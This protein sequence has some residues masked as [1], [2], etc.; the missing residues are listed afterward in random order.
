MKRLVTFLILISSCQLFSEESSESFD[1][2]H[3][4]FIENKNSFD[5][6]LL[7]IQ[8]RLTEVKE[9]LGNIS[10][11]LDKLP[12]NNEVIPV[13]EEEVIDIQSFPKEPEDS[14]KVYHY[15]PEKREPG[16]HAVSYDDCYHQETPI[17]EE[18]Y[19]YTPENAEPIVDRVPYCDCY[20]EEAPLYEVP[21][22]TR[23]TRKYDVNVSA[24][25]LYWFADVSNLS[26]AIKRKKSPGAYPKKKLEFSSSWDPGV[27]LGFNTEPA[28]GC[29]DLQ[30][31]WTFF[32]TSKSASNTGSDNVT[33][34]GAEVFT[35]P[36]TV[37]RFLNYSSVN[38][39]YGVLFN[40]IDLSVGKRKKLFK[41]LDT[42]FFCG[43]R[44]FWSRLSFDLEVSRPLVEDTQD[45]I[46]STAKHRQ[47]EWGVGILAG[48]E[49]TYQLYQC[50]SLIG[51]ANLALTY[52][53]SSITIDKY[54]FQRDAFYF[55]VARDM[56]YTVRDNDYRMQSFVD[57]SLGTR[58]EP[59]ICGCSKFT[60][61]LLWE[62]HYLYSYNRLPR[63]N[64]FPPNRVDLFNVSGN[65]LLSGLA[66]RLN[67]NF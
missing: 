26:Y 38:A 50:W 30:A 64:A 31:N 32:D 34:E 21:E 36:W 5:D 61:D 29:W 48:V 7:E 28:I 20:F 62:F 47:T 6:K 65:L 9:S 55:I 58:F 12:T 14:K 3:Q 57:L 56:K 66:L 43:L 53:R 67:L 15:T 25:F 40:Q 19:R 60:L 44:G 46:D 23:W 17:Y 45:L 52:G 22:R 18:V 11:E 8:N 59:T 16:V 35:S 51:Q 24:D 49:N 1:A 4:P 2:E 13:Y 10:S 41:C 27:R 54:L 39:K 63:G 33:L 42:R 37:E